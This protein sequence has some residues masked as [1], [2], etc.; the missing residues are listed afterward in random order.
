MPKV[1][2]FL[3]FSGTAVEAMTFYTSLLPD[4]AILDVEYY[5]PN[6]EG[7][8]GTVRVATFTLN[9]Q[10]YMAIDTSIEHAWTFTP[11]ISLH[12]TCE[13]PAEVD[14]LYVALSQDG[15]VFM[16]LDTYPFSPRYTWFS[17]KFGVS[18]QIMFVE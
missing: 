11:A 13:S 15:E 7:A 2:T 9:G 4:S 5:G 8:E 1:K 12:V 18:W 14:R 16:P 17:D 3:T 6:E 10:E